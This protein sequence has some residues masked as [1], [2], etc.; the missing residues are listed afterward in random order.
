MCLLTK[1]PLSN[2]MLEKVEANFSPLFKARKILLIL[3]CLLGFP[4]KAQH[5]ELNEF[6]FC[7]FLEYTRYSI[8]L[9]LIFVTNFYNIHLF[10][11]L[12]QLSNPVEVYK[13]Y[14]TRILGFTTLDILVLTSMPYIT[15]ISTAFYLNSFKKMAANI[16]HVCKFL[17]NLNK[18]LHEAVHLQMTYKR[19][20]KLRLSYKLFFFG[21]FCS[22][23][24]LLTYLT[25]FYIVM[26]AVANEYPMSQAQKLTFSVS[27]IILAFCWI[28]PSM[29]MSADFIV[30]HILEETG[31]VY[32]IWN[33]L[34]TLYKSKLEKF[35]HLK[36]PENG[37]LHQQIYNMERYELPSYFETRIALIFLYDDFESRERFLL[38]L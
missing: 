21:A 16:S 8:Y 38:S 23:L 35:D 17:T 5:Q 11:E 6:K 1:V 34:L 14:F 10:M 29:T 31:D 20:S 12:S 37:D 32:L 36:E 13:E 19:N 30:C 26:E 4:L 7:S 27:S 15:W 2:T 28:Y 33:D 18:E 25:S 3:R 24:I 9:A 22:I